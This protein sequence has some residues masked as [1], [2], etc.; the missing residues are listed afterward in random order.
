MNP[1]I[2]SHELISTYN[3]VEKLLA[4][5]KEKS[6]NLSTFVES[7]LGPSFG[8]AIGIYAG[9]FKALAVRDRKEFEEKIK[10]QYSHSKG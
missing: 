3:A 7:Q 9:L 6:K 4:E 8:P 5:A 1:D 2:I 10:S